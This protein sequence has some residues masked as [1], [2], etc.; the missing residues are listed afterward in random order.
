M[1]KFLLLI[2][3][4]SVSLL[5]VFPGITS[6]KILHNCV[7]KYHFEP[8]AHHKNL[9]GDGVEN[10]IISD[11]IDGA[12][13]NLTPSNVSLFS[14]GESLQIHKRV[15]AV[16]MRFFS[17]PTALSIVYWLTFALCFFALFNFLDAWKV[18][19]AINLALSVGF[20]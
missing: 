10:P 15:P 14:I 3:I 9:I 4:F 8:W 20:A 17:S 7:Y 11:S 5:L 13:A 2:C 18:P 19:T 1:K 6:G 16:L 12:D